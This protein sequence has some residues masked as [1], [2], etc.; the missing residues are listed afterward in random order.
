MGLGARWCRVYSELSLLA[1]ESCKVNQSPISITENSGWVIRG[2]RVDRDWTQ[3]ARWRL[4]A[5]LVV[6]SCI[7]DTVVYPRLRVVRADWA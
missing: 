7:S 5:N 2:V 3:G 1:V 4:H 6:F